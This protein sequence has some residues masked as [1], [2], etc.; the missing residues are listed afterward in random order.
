M[1]L[2][3]GR[4][5]FGHDPAGQ[6][7]FDIPTREVL[8]VDPSSRWIR[9]QLGGETVVD[10]KRAKLLHQHGALPRY[11]VPRD[12]V[13][14]DQLPGIEPVEPPAGAPG[15]EDHVAFPWR[16]FD[17]WYEEDEQ[18]MGHPIDPYHRVDVRPTSRHVAISIGG[19]VIAD[20]TAAMALFETGGPPRWYLPREDIRAELEPSDLHTRCAYKGEATYFSVRVGDDLAENV[21]WTYREPRHDASAVRDLVCFFNEAVDID[22]DGERQER[23]MTP[24]SRPGWWQGR[25]GAPE[26]PQGV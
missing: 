26:G 5:P 17:A 15:L 12:D 11:F 8:F 25:T 23:P 3:V 21:A 19:E 18:V 10:S 20:T 7:N 2:T 14:W 13:R 16:T 9:A 24:W 4:G 1:S 6:F 22:L